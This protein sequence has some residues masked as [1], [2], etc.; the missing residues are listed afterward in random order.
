[1]EITMRLFPDDFE[2]VKS[3]KK[4]R[5]Y[6]LNDEKRRLLRIGDTIRFR[7]LPNLDEEFLVEVT[8]IETY[9]NWEECYAAHFDEDFKDTYVY[10]QCYSKCYG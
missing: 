8:N 1:M 3:G 10:R 5:E 9:P 7:K 4:K 2:D 6:R